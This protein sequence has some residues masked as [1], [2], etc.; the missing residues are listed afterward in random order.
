MPIDSIPFFSRPRQ[1]AWLADEQ[2]RESLI[3]EKI[4][5]AR[6]MATKT[7]AGTRAHPPDVSCENSSSCRARSDFNASE[8]FCKYFAARTQ[9]KSAVESVVEEV[10]GGGG[11]KARD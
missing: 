7:L 6:A 9:I 1:S 4:R 2:S 3:N 11:K 8:C 5:L 10:D